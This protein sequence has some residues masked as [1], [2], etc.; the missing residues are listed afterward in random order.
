MSSCLALLLGNLLEDRVAGE[1]R[2]GGAEA[3]VG[4]GVNALLLEVVEELG[5]W[6]VG[7]ELNLVDS[8]DSLA[9]W[10]VQ[11]DLEV[12]DGEVGDTDV[13]DA[14]RSR[15]LLE[16][17][18]CVDEVPVGVVLLEVVGVGGGWP[19]HKV[20]VNVVNTEVL[21]RRGDALFDTLVPWVVKLGC[22]PNLLTG[23]TRVLDSLTDLGL[24]AVCESGIDVAVTSEESSLDGL[25]DL[26]GL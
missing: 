13:L 16:L 24:V 18:P 17:S 6:V 2:V 5:R 15:E 20:Q 25:T 11:E 1:G 26:V 19:V 9:G 21:E 7:V 3:R 22:D 14:A 12:L 4:G 23:D 10:V 8:G